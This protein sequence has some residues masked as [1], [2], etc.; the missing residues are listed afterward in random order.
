MSFLVV[1]H[2][3]SPRSC[4]SI[5]HEFPDISNLVS[6]SLPKCSLQRT[7]IGRRLR[8]FASLRG[9]SDEQFLLEVQ[10]SSD[11]LAQDRCNILHRDHR[12]RFRR[13]IVEPEF[14]LNTLRCS[15]GLHPVRRAMDLDTRAFFPDH[16]LNFTDKM[17]MQSGVEIRVPLLDVRLVKFARSCRWAKRSICGTERSSC[18]DLKG[19]GFQAR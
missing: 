16:S 9:L 17:G 3:T 1:T 4:G 18:A 14:L 5:S 10:S 12:E 11:L 7:L 19:G 15:D 6:T 8:R 13:D 2:G